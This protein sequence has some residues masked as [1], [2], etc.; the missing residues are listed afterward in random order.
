MGNILTYNGDL[1]PYSGGWN[2]ERVWN[3]NG[4]PLFGFPMALSFEQI[5]SHFVLNH[6]KPEQNGHHFVGISNETLAKF[7][8]T[9]LSP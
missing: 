4:C 6:R 7:T 1:T 9:C 8:V 3:S 2:K 5:G